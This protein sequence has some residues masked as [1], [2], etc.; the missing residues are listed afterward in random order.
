MQKSLLDKRGVGVKDILL[1]LAFFVCLFSGVLRHVIGAGFLNFFAVTIVFCA[2]FSFLVAGGVRWVRWGDAFLFLMVFLCFFLAFFIRGEVNSRAVFFSAEML[3]YLVLAY[4]LVVNDVDLLFVARAMLYGFWLFFVYKCMTVGYAPNDMNGYLAD[5]SRNIVS[6]LAIFFQI[7]YSVTYYDRYS[8]LPVVSAF[9]TVVICVMAFGRSGVLLS[10][11]LF[12]FSIYFNSARKGAAWV[13]ALLV[14]AVSVLGYIGAEVYVYLSEKTNFSR[15]LESARSIMISEYFEGF[16]F[17]H[18]FFGRSFDEM[19]TIVGL[20]GNP[21]NSY[22][23]G[24]HFF[25]GAYVALLI[26]ILIIV[27]RSILNKERRVYGV[28]SAV[29]LARAF[30]DILAM[31]G[32]LDGI[33]FYTLLKASGGGAKV[34]RAPQPFE[35][36]AHHHEIYRIQYR[37]R[38]GH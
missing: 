19:P 11:V 22:I 28:L 36:N 6:A 21:H 37:R 4:V 35:Q 30:F 23:L 32:F 12:C 16:S 31:P 24:H 5:A 2:A 33:L 29:F 26:F 15:G 27:A 8:R 38:D 7:F 34:E 25:G 9:V 18:V 3:L 14:L 17:S 20:A 13:F 10:L 1:S